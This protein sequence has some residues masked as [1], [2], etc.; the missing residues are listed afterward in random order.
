MSIDY[1]DMYDAV[2]EAEKTFRVAD[3]MA[4]KTAPLLV[5]RL[6]KCPGATLA[7]LKQ[8]LTKFN[9]HTWEWKD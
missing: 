2:S 1:Q 5:G 4:E 6:R 9:G 8:E 7:L 3:K